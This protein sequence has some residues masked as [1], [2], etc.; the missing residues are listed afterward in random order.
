MRQQFRR[1]KFKFW[2][3]KFVTPY[4]LLGVAMPELLSALRSLV[5]RREHKRQEKLLQ[6]QRS[7]ACQAF[8]CVALLGCNPDECTCLESKQSCTRGACHVCADL[9]YNR[10]FGGERRNIMSRQ[11][12]RIS[13][14]DTLDAFFQ[15]IPW[16]SF[17][18]PGVTN[19]SVLTINTAL[20]LSC[21]VACVIADSGR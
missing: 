18:V 17:S 12:E 2:A 7:S 15:I 16:L 6:E 8:R 10:H 1:S 14:A 11:L 19:L 20:A 3:S 9:W 21:F 4:V 5:G 13:S